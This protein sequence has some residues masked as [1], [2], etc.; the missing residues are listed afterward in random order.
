MPKSRQFLSTTN[1]KP[2]HNYIVLA[3]YLFLCSGKADYFLSTL[4]IKLLLIEHLTSV[5]EQLYKT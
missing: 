3:I 1:V 2:L 4:N 5:Y